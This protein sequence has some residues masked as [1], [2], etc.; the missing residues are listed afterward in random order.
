MQR[1]RSLFSLRGFFFLLAALLL[2]IF[3]FS[4]G[5]TS[6]RPDFLPLPSKTLTD[7]CSWE[8]DFRPLHLQEF[9]DVEILG[10]SYPS[11]PR[12]LRVHAT[13]RPGASYAPYREFW[14]TVQEGSWE[15]TTFQVIKAALTA[16]MGAGR[17]VHLDIGS[18]VGP[19]ALFAALL[20]PRVLA[21][22]PDP[23]AFNELHANALLNEALA[24]RL[25]LFRHCLASAT[26]PRTMTGPAPLGSSMSR[27]AG[28]ARIPAS[29]S[30]EESWGERMV[31]FHS[32]CSTPL[33]FAARAGLR[34]SEL[35]LIKLDVEGAEADILPALVDWLEQEGGVKPPLLVELHALFWADPAAGARA[36][37]GAMAKYAFAFASEVERPGRR[38]LDNVLAAYRPGTLLAE[39]GSLCP[40]AQSFCMVL[41]V[42]EPLPWVQDL[43][44]AARD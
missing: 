34:A 13:K 2:A 8:A 11:L 32:P 30:A 36:A 10:L 25:E 26:G 18:W 12:P 44:V 15:P 40:Q 35:A 5:R 19:T 16:G 43:L 14:L 27:V 33:A 1:K 42:D 39:T 3:S 21:I 23:R 38:V 31:S 41:L 37:A 29:A 4:L 9:L 22:E 20:V 28:A 6:R 7:V 24:P 17:E